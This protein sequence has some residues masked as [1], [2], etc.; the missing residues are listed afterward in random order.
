MSR[1]SRALICCVTVLSLAA[2]SARPPPVDALYAS[3]AV[4]VGACRDLYAALDAMVEDA[5]VGDAQSARIAGYPYLRIER[6]LAADAIRPTAD[7][8]D[9]QIWVGRL[10]DLDLQARHYELENLSSGIDAGDR[11]RV[12]T[13]LAACAEALIADEL[14]TADKRA[15]LLGAARVPDHYN[16]TGRVFGLYPFTSLAF[17]SGVDAYQESTRETFSLSLESLP[18]EG[19]LVRYV[20]PSGR[21]SLSLDAVASLLRTAD[22]EPLGVPSLTD[23]QWERLFD[24]FAPVYE[25][26]VVDDDD[27]IGMPVWADDGLPSVDVRRPVVFRRVSYTRF[28]GQTLVQLVYSAWFPARPSEGD[29]DVL[30]GRLDGI[31]FRVTLGRDARPLVY[32]S[33]HNCGCYHMFVPTTHLRERPIGDQHEEPLLVPQRI[34]PGEGRIVLRIANRTHYLQRVYFDDAA[35]DG[36]AYTLLDDD[37]L[38]SLPAKDGRWRSL[39]EPDGIVSGTQRGERWFFWPMGISNPGAMR[40]WGHH[41]TLFVGKRHFDDIDIIERYFFSA[42][43]EPEPT[44]K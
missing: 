12:E 32:D 19:R 44:A 29:F 3:T 34:E 36:E 14:D 25:I 39:F 13:R 22:G 5:G 11:A 23:A 4:G 6:F 15:R 21:A 1:R 17:K 35:S 10:R 41:A 20:P 9:F 16:V 27:R 42:D 28:E 24:T 18:V 31:T 38:R 26:D 8:A 2:C 30:S 7:G 33:M 43:G 37:S 40:Q